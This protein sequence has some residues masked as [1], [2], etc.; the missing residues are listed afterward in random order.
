MIV[1]RSGAGCVAVAVALVVVLDV[2]DVAL[3]AFV[4]DSPQAVIEPSTK[5]TE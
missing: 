4:A 2:E 1:G 5:A 3:A